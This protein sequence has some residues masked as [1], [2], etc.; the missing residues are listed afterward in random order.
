M[1]VKLWDAVYVHVCG[2]CVKEK[3]RDRD[4][5]GDREERA[6]PSQRSL[7]L[8]AALSLAAAVSPAQS[9]PPAGDIVRC[10]LALQ[11]SCAVRNPG[12]R[13][14]LEKNEGFGKERR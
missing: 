9:L 13:A 1:H 8:S 11:R 4:S 3:E 5:N 12:G 2:V 6:H 14:V 10:H 7:G